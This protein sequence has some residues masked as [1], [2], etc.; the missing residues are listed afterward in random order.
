MTLFKLIANVSITL[1][2]HSTGC[3]RNKYRK[4]FFTSMKWFLKSINNLAKHFRKLLTRSRFV[5][6]ILVGYEVQLQLARNKWDFEKYV[7]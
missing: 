1:L 6:R 7:P 4:S 3:G 5:C 2:F